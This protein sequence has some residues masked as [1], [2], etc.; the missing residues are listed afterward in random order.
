M[1][2]RAVT[3]H[4]EVPAL[5]VFVLYDAA[6]QHFTGLHVVACRVVLGG[7]AGGGGGGTLW[8]RLL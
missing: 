2:E 6:L 1:R 4:R 7:V 5:H 8:G 3:L